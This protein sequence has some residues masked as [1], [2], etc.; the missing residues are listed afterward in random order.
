MPM[1][2]YESDYLSFKEIF[3][4]PREEVLKNIRTKEI[5]SEIKAGT[6]DRDT[7][8][9]EVLIEKH[10]IR[11]GQDLLIEQIMI[12]GLILTRVFS[13]S[14]AKLRIPISKLVL[15]FSMK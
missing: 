3:V 13:F 1:R 15:L 6:P 10:R 2:R 5:P 4:Q 11:V 9:D 8:N 12:L 14:I 7:T